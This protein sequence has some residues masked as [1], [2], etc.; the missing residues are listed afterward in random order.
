MEDEY[1]EIEIDELV[2]KTDEAILIR[3][4]DEKTWVPQ[5]Q[6]EDWPDEGDPGTVLMKE[7]IA[8]EKDLI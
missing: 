6:C 2:K 1:I 5:S 7:W 4:G 3:I 8:V